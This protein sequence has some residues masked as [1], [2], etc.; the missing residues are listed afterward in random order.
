MNDQ[1]AKLGQDPVEL[2]AHGGEG[3]CLDLDQEVAPLDVDDETVELDFER[4]AGLG[5]QVLQGSM[6]RA[7]IQGAD[8]CDWPSLGHGLVGGGDG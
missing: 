8:V 2:A 6:E 5:Q 4:I 7:L 1:H 3:R